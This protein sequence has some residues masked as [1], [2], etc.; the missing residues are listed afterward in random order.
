MFKLS[1]GAIY[2]I[3]SYLD[4]GRNK[5]LENSALFGGAI[6]SEKSKV[7]IFDNYFNLNYAS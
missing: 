6:Y 7:L 3:Y 2:G 1:G 4:I 5:F